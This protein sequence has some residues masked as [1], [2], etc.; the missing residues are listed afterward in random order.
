VK[1]LVATAP[2]DLARLDE[3]HVSAATLVF[4]FCLSAGCGVLCGLWPA[5]RATSVEPADALRSASRSVTEGRAR[6][7]SREWLVGLE[8]ALSTVLLVAAALL[9]LSLLRLSDVEPGYGVDHILTADLA[10]PE[11]TYRKDEQRALF[12]E[13]ALEKLEALPGVQSAG[14]ISSLPLKTQSW[15]DVI[16]K[17][18]ATLPRAL[19]PKAEFRFISE[20]YFETM[21]I[22]LRA[23]R[24]PASRDHAHKVV[25]VSASAARSVWPG[26]N[27]I[28]KRLR[29]DPRTDWAEVIGVAADVRSENLE[30]QPRLMVYVPYWDGA[31]WQGSV[32]GNA[33]YVMR[34]W[35]DPAAMANALRSAM[36]ELDPQLPLENVLTMREIVSKSVSRRKFQTLLTCVFAGAAL[37]LACLGIYG[38][39]SYSVARRKVEVGVRIALGAQASQVSMLVLRQGIRPVLGGLGAGIAGALA[40]GRFLA[41]FLFGTPAHDPAAISA[42]VLLLLL[43]ALAACWTP[44]RRAARIDPMVALRDE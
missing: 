9:G 25:V 39:I 14:L 35:Q 43:V 5:L 37:L 26:E 4:A 29:N 33:T 22:G 23:G 24:F 11:A 12:H 31:Y 10:L 34:T 28:G 17:E 7:R 27:P 16:N 1:L 42:V 6:V 32:W 13:R 38:V 44:A 3:V 15:G 2:V 19:R 41:S 20:H 30:T 40:A 21:G 8:V 36:R 18:G